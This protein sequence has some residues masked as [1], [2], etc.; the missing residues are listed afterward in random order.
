MIDFAARLQGT[1][2]HASVMVRS[3]SNIRYRGHPGT[4]TTWLRYAVCMRH[5]CVMVWI[6]SLQIPGTG[7]IPVP[8]LPDCGRL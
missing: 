2:V 5:V 1:R 4:G 8:V 3:F 7:T 6:R